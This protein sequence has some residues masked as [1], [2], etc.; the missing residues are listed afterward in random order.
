MANIV[1][2][3]PNDA[4]KIKTFQKLPFE[5]V[6]TNTL[7]CFATETAEFFLVYVFLDEFESSFGIRALFGKRPTPLLVRS[8]LHYIHDWN[9]NQ[10]SLF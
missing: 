9:R 1:E 8:I 6:L 3:I 4:S 5:I 2:K 7:V 10:G